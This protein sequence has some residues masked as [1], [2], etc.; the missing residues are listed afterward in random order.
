MNTRSHAR[1]L[2][3]QALTIALAL[4]LAPAVARAHHTA[5]DHD[6]ATAS[7]HKAKAAPSF[8]KAATKAK[9]MA[10][11]Q[12]GE[13]VSAAVRKSTELRVMGL[14]RQIDLEAESDHAAFMERLSTEFGE[15]IARIAS[16]RTMSR[17]PWGEYVIA[18]TLRASV[19]FPITTSQIVALHRDGMAWAMVAHGLGLD[20]ESFVRAIDAERQVALGESR[21]NGRV[22]RIVAAGGNTSARVDD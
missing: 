19:G 21:P 7:D 14:A 15:P 13:A 5:G 18:H 2:A 6:P 9:I 17:A 10:I 20:V 16:Q 1:A 11:E 3:A 8:Q 12:R 22:A 4:L